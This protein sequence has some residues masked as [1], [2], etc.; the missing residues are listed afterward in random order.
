M[1]AWE[2]SNSCVGRWHDSN[3]KVLQGI[4]L[5]WCDDDKE[6]DKENS[7][8]QHPGHHTNSGWGMHIAH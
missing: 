5:E 4:N 1:T 7:H 8:S 2:G 6:N 3:G